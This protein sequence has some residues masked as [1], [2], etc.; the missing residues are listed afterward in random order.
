MERQKLTHLFTLNFFFFFFFLPLEA[1][2]SSLSK[3]TLHHFNHFFSS[4]HYSLIN[5]HLLK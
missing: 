5:A 4:K 1:C 3:I 2:Q